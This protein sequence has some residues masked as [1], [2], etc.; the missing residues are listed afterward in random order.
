MMR[1]PSQRTHNGRQE[2]IWAFSACRAKTQCNAVP[3]KMTTP[4]QHVHNGCQEKMRAPS[5]WAVGTEKNT[6]IKMMVF[7][8]RVP[9]QH[10]H[11]HLG[12]RKDEGASS[13]HHGHMTKKQHNNQN[14]CVAIF[15]FY[16]QA[17]KQKNIFSF[18][19]ANLLKQIKS[20]NRFAQV[21]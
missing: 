19:H 4:S 6:T 7:L 17:N 5:Q 2:K 20:F 16:C 12:P 8:T 13:P 18:H 10:G 11:N 14:E 3:A 1:A 21:Y 15:Y 9:S